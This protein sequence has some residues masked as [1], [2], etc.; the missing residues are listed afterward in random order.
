MSKAIAIFDGKVKGFI[1]FYQPKNSNYV[2]IIFNLKLPS[3]NKTYACHV[4][5]YGDTRDS[6]KSLGGHWNPTNKYHGSNNN[7]KLNHHHGDLI[8]NIKSNSNKKYKFSYVDKLVKLRGKNHIYGRSVVIH[9]GIDDLGLG[10][11]K[12]SL[13]TGNAGKRID[14]GIIVRYKK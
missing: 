13:I 8:N 9:S 5:E 14:C 1:K 11:N 2:N 4:H 7:N 12:E 6:C 10:K 3:K